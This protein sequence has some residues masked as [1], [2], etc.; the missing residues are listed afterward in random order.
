MTVQF[1]GRKNYEVEVTRK[2][3]NHLLEITMTTGPMK[4]VATYLFE[5]SNGGT[6]FIRHVD[7]PMEGPMRLLRPLIR[8]NVEKRNEQF[9]QNL[10]SLLEA[11]AA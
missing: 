5:P 1:M 2:E 9:V 10:K 3:D 8:R 7:V 4:P 6:H 11:R